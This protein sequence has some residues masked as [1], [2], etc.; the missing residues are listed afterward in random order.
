[1]ISSKHSLALMALVASTSYQSS[2]ALFCNTRR[3]KKFCLR[4]MERGRSP[5]PR[6]CDKFKVAS[7]VPSPPVSLPSG[8]A[9]LA[10]SIPTALK[11]SSAP[12]A[13]KAPSAPT[14]PNAPVAIGVPTK[15]PTRLIFDQH[16]LYPSSFV[17]P[18]SPT[19]AP[20]S[21]AP[22]QKIGLP[23]PACRTCV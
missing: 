16:F 11:V 21:K 12:A 22:T 9:P 17:V 15:S 4:M 13:P 1:M 23:G 8:I 19:K 14:V 18:V 7:T 20:Q 3:G 6:C 2:W 5:I 10:P